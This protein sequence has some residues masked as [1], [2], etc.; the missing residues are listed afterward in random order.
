[1][2]NNLSVCPIHKV[3]YA[4]CP[5]ERIVNVHGGSMPAQRDADKYLRDNDAELIGQVFM[6]RDGHYTGN[7]AVKVGGKLYINPPFVLGVTSGK[8][9]K[10]PTGDE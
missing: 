5:C 10:K 4:D 7:W 1:M 3:Y 2:S 6:L 8:K 9:K